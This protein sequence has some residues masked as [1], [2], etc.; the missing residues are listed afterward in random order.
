VRLVDANVLLNAVNEDSREHPAARGWLEDSL[1]GNEAVGFAWVVLLAFI[2]VSTRPGIFA[3][4]FDAE[5]ACTYVEEWLTQPVSVVVNPTPRHLSILTSLLDDAGTGGNLTTDAH[6]AALA[7]E[8]GAEVW[9]FD[10]D[11]ARFR[12]LKA[13]VPAA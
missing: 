10:R 7:L 9:S 2:R 6:L 3:R 12:G 5:T 8:H 4:P 11:F 13:R 1:N